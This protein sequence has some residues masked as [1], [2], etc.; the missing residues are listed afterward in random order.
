MPTIMSR[1]IPYNR[2][3]KQSDVSVTV[4]KHLRRF[5]YAARFDTDRFELPLV[6]WWSI[7]SM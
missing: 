5:E 3:S 2:K 7:I 1:A 6:E 4:Q